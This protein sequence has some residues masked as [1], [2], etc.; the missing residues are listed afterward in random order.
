[1]YIIIRFSKRGSRIKQS[2]AND[3]ARREPTGRLAPGCRRRRPKSKFTK[4]SIANL[5]VVR[6]AESTLPDIPRLTCYLGV[7]YI[8]QRELQETNKTKKPC[9]ITLN[10]TGRVT[11]NRVILLYL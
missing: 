6:A 10:P 8:S 9:I 3:F 2:G 1:M 11:M 7:P 4:G 5:V